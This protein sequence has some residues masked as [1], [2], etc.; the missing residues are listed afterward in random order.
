M[1]RTHPL[2]I[3]QT[4][5]LASELYELELAS[6]HDASTRIRFRT[7]DRAIYDAALLVEGTDV[8]VRVDWHWVGSVRMLDAIHPV[9]PEEE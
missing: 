6:D 9:R 1:Q 2:V 8:R 3:A 5:Y 7:H 4:W